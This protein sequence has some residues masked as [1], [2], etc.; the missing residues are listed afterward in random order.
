MKVGRIANPAMTLALGLCI[1]HEGGAAPPL[2]RSHAVFGGE[3][4]VQLPSPSV[5]AVVLRANQ[6]RTFTRSGCSGDM[7]RVANRFCID[8]YEASMLDDLGSRV[9]SPYYPP[10]AALLR[11][12]SGEWNARLSKGEAGVDVPLPTIFV[13][14]RD[15]AYHPVA[16][17]RAGVVPQGYVN[18][19]IAEAACASAGKRLCSEEEWTTA[20]RG[21]RGTKFP[22]G[23]SY[24][25]GACNVF[26]YEH[27]G[28]ILHG[29]FSVDLLDPRLNAVVVEGETLL[30]P[31][32]CDTRLQKRVGRRRGLRHGGQ[33]R[34]VHR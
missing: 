12:I 2:P 10:V 18:R 7:V 14:Q 17:S 5:T 29:S 11:P 1:T 13:W 3:E 26:R 21:Q 8:R 23:P 33:P 4:G 19:P 25:Q 20:C 15:E 22:Y 30:R 31:D 16:S 34:R 9:I 24:R 28:M 27:P 6:A 32:R